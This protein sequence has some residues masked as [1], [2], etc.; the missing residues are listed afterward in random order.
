MKNVPVVHPLRSGSSA[1]Y[2]SFVQILEMGMLTSKHFELPQV[3]KSQQSQKS[4]SFS[5]VARNILNAGFRCLQKGR[6]GTNLTNVTL[7][8]YI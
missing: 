8:S 2:F 6:N 1:T 3:L 5:Y 7:H 4:V